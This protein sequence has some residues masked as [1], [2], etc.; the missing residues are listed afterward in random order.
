MALPKRSYLDLD[1]EFQRGGGQRAF[2]TSL[3]VSGEWMNHPDS[4]SDDGARLDLDSR[5]QVLL[6][7]YP[8]SVRM[9]LES[10]GSLELMRF[11]K[12]LQLNLAF[13]HYKLFNSSPADVTVVIGIVYIPVEEEEEEEEGS[14]ERT[15]NWETDVLSECVRVDAATAPIRV[16]VPDELRAVE[17]IT[18]HHHA[19]DARLPPVRRFVIIV[20]YFGG[21]GGGGVWR[22]EIQGWACRRIAADGARGY[23]LPIPRLCFLLL[24]KV[25]LEIEFSRPIGGMDKVVAYA[26][27]GG[28]ATELGGMMGMLV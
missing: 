20:R 17:Y 16:R 6:R 28:V 14:D 9:E 3:R 13:P 11:M 8:E 22:G 27:T 10:D 24:D 26:R 18:V 12:R 15:A 1:K 5:G 21:G 4:D 19:H 23:R 2:V 25:D 7:M